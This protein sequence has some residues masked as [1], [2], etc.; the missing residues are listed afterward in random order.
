MKNLLIATVALFALAAPAHAGSTLAI[1]GSGGSNTAG[2]LAAVTT[3]GLAVGAA[4]GVGISTGQS[5]GVAVATPLGGL[6]AGI[7]QTNNF[8]AA[9]SGVIAGFGGSG[10]AGSAGNGTGINVGGGITNVLP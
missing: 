5:A 10:A 8:G 3:H 2:S 7:G 9:G 1:A 6:S 4:G